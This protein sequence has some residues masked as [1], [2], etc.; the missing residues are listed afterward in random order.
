M[1]DSQFD[2]ALNREMEDAIK[3]ASHRL[4]IFRA[5]SAV[6]AGDPKELE[7]EQPAIASEVQGLVEERCRAVAARMDSGELEA[8]VSRERVDP[9]ELETWLSEA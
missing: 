5:L 9:S 8:L 3:A 2:R 6:L 4:R 1:Q 7:R